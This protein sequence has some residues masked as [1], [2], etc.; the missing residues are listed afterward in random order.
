MSD[1]ITTLHPENDETTNLYP[2]IKKE[3]IPSKSIDNTKLDDAINSL[4]NNIGELH[5]SGVDT[6]TNILAYTTDK[7][8]YIGSNNGHWYYWNGTQYADGG[9]YQATAIADGEITLNKLNQS[10]KNILVYGDGVLPNDITDLNNDS[11][12]NKIYRVLSDKTSEDLA[13]CPYYPFQGVIYTF[14]SGFSSVCVLQIVQR[15]SGL[16]Y[17]R[18]K[19]AAWSSWKQIADTSITD[20]LLDNI[21]Y[22]SGITMKYY[23]YT[24]YLDFNETP[25]NSII[26]YTNLTGVTNNPIDEQG[27]LL[28]F[29]STDTTKTQYYNTASNK[30]FVRHLWDVNWSS[31][32]QII[33]KDEIEQLIS[34]KSSGNLLAMYSNLR[35]IGDSLT[36]S[37][38]YTSATESRQARQ[39]Y[40]QIVSKLSGNIPFNAYAFGGANATTW[41]NTFNQNLV[42][43]DNILNFVYLGTNDGLTDTIDTDCVGDDLTQFANT[44]TGNYGRILQRIKD[45]GQ[46]AVLI[47]IY[48]TNA[49][50]DVTNSVIEKFGQRYGFPV[51][52][53]IK[54]YENCYHYYPDKTGTNG[55]HYNDL[56]YSKFANTL[57]QKINNLDETMLTRLVN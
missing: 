14:Y 30:S 57:I 3:N 25:R 7:G 34:S 54:Y 55:V 36:Y 24:S 9:V 31:W 45:L 4:L 50:V 48:V 47:K 19:W 2:N 20:N 8:I 42:A 52:D 13:N 21:N 5:P 35:F 10:L 46:K 40:P 33:Y 17:F 29:A 15:S 22:L 27:T 49:D 43:S 6:S 12:H 18:T 41:W 37:Q 28:T 38:V 16:L 44:L 39:T 23:G 51:I 1:I 11:L 56:G 53:A 32:K 26:S